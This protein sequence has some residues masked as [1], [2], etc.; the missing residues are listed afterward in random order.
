MAQLQ[1]ATFELE[2]FELAGDARLEVR[3]RWF[4][5]RGRRFMRPTLTAMADGREQ[6]ILALLDHKPWN[7]EDGE[8]W[9][10]AFPSPAD[11]IELIGAE[12]TVAPGVTVALPA[13][14]A[15]ASPRRRKGGAPRRSDRSEA[16]SGE[17]RG[18]PGVP[19][20]L[21]RDRAVKARDEMLAEIAKAK[22]DGR[23][24]SD[25][26]NR[27]LAARDAVIAERHELIEREVRLRVAGLRAEVARERAGARLAAQSAL[28]RDEARAAC[29]ETARERDAGWVE[30][31]NA[32]SERNRLLAQ[33]DAARRR[34]QEITRQWEQ[35]AALGTRRTL[36]RDSL[37]VEHDR[38]RRDLDAALEERD[39]LRRDLDAAL[40]ERDRLR[41]DLDAALEER[42]GIARDRD[43]ARRACEEAMHEREAALEARQS[44]VGERDVALAGRKSVAD[45]DD[46]T[47][48]ERRPP[49]PPRRAVPVDR[50]A[51]QRARG[52]LLDD[53]TAT[54]LIQGFRP[55]ERRPSAAGTPPGAL[56][57]SPLADHRDLAHLWRARLLA[58]AALILA[59][60]VLLVI[61]LAR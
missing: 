39:R 2:R 30:R 60:I 35:T 44:A 41:R 1:T 50:E 17:D 51:G 23:Q 33:R 13:P 27:A 59:M 55:D 40:E 3:G 10:A 57:S 32:Q 45:E 6:R 25:E 46:P 37:A 38:L 24:L 14:S 56:A 7:A 22:R 19:S 20:D 21:E 29:E 53:E 36:E 43:L 52:S 11:P 58:V 47:V 5:V 26:R 34:V 61:V 54:T 48:E 9:L 4:G 31:D 42:D 49:A 18:E 12:L 16:S 15:G 28:Q 8:T